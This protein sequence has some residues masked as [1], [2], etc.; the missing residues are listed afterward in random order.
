MAMKNT[1]FQVP[2]I[3]WGRITRDRFRGSFNGFIFK[4]PIYLPTYHKYGKMVRCIKNGE[5]N[6]YSLYY[7]LMTI[8]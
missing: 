3:L 7:S 5:E 8:L 2:H 4:L 6:R 1:K